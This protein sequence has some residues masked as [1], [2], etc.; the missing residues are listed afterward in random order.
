MGRLMRFLSRQTKAYCRAQTA[1]EA[2]IEL[3]YVREKARLERRSFITAE[4]VE[5]QEKAVLWAHHSG[6]S[7]IS[8]QF[9]LNQGEEKAR[10]ENQGWFR[11]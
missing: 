1:E 9:F 7:D 2:L 8:M 6:M 4:N 5:L 3:G 11:C 10:K